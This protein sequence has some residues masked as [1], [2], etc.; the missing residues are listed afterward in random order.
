MRWPKRRAA[1]LIMLTITINAAS[2]STL[3]DRCGLADNCNMRTAALLCTFLTTSFYATGGTRPL[4]ATLE[5]FDRYVELT[6]AELKNSAESKIFLSGD[7][8][9]Q[10]RARAGEMVVKERGRTDQDPKFD[11]PNGIIQD[12]KGLMFVPGISLDRFRRFLQDYGNYKNLYQ[13][14]VLESRLKSRDGDQFEVF[15]RL[16]KKALLT[17]VLNVDYRI[18]YSFPQP[19][20][21][22]VVSRSTRI[23]EVKKADRPD[24]AEYPVGNDTGL[25]WRL[26]TYWQAEEADG[27]VY[28]QCEAVSLSRDAPLGLG[29]IL[30]GFLAQF[31]RGSMTDTLRQTREG[32]LAKP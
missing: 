19:H 17:V 8:E 9:T 22:L 31:P 30:K 12:W 24:T 26:N 28:A 4:P 27:G 23:A 15:L 13:P 2:L 6:E 5:A 16:Y 7:R 32:L 3:A 18:Q 1:F 21:M 11:P 25:L 29:L 10:G 20:R 14:A